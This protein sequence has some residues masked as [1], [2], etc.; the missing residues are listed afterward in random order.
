VRACVGRGGVGVADLIQGIEAR[1]KVTH[2]HTDRQAGRQAGRLGRQ[3]DRL[4]GRKGR[5]AEK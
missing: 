3:T 4:A 2:R 5:Q 1:R